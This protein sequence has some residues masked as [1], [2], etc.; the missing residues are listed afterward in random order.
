M[1]PL[2]RIIQFADLIRKYKKFKTTEKQWLLS[3]LSADCVKFFV[4]LLIN[5]ERIELSVKTKKDLKAHE[6]TIKAL[7]NK[8]HS[9]VRRKAIIVKAGKSFVKVSRQKQEDLP[10]RV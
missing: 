1:T 8:K 2:P 4:E 10:S 9:L 6:K 7:V 3:S 5:R